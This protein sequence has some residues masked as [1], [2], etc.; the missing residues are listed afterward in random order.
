V[1]KILVVVKK[2]PSTF[3]NYWFNFSVHFMERLFIKY[4]KLG[5]VD[6][7]EWSKRVWTLLSSYNQ[8]LL[9]DG[10]T[11]ESEK[12]NLPEFRSEVKFL[13]I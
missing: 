13:I 1:I 11:L 9:K 3:L 2:F 8:R 10:K 12:E 5:I 4:I 6:T 7:D